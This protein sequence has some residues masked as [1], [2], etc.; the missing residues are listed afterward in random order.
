ML[1]VIL[2]AELNVNPGTTYTRK[3]KASRDAAMHVNLTPI[4]GNEGSL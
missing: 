2:V 3:K 4:K 1:I